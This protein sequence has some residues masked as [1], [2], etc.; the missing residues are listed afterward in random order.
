KALE[1]QIRQRLELQEAHDDHLIMKEKK[2]IAELAE[3]EEYRR[4]LMAKFAEDDRIELMNAQKRRMKQLEHRRAVEKLIEERRQEYQ[5]LKE[6][7][8]LERKE[9]ERQESMRRAIV[10]QERQRLL[11][12]HATKLLGYLPK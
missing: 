6:L 8:V 11:R 1:V 12:E 9:E 7:E 4:Q 5:R 2:R 3:E 10:E